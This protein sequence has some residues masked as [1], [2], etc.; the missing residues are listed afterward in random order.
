MMLRWLMTVLVCLFVSSSVPVSAQGGLEEALRGLPP[1]ERT[2]YREQL[3][4]LDRVASRLLK[5]VPDAPQVNF[6]LA[7]GENSVNAGATFGKVIVTEGMMRFVNSDDELAMILGHEFAH[8]TQGHVT[9]GAVNNTLLGIGS[10]I[11]G[12][13]M[14]GAGQAT[15]LVGQL[16]LNRFNQS[17]ERE[18]DQVGLRYVYAAG[19]SPEAAA[20][21]MQRMAE[22]V[23]QTAAAGFF[24]SHPSSIERFQALQQLA[25]QLDTGRGERYVNDNT[26]PQRS[27]SGRDEKVCQKA[28]PYFHQAQ[29]AG[30]LNEKVKLYR[31]GLRLCPQ[32]PRAHSELADVYIELGEE[33]KA[34]AE[35]REVLRYDAEY[36]EARSRLRGLEDNLSQLREW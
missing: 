1:G 14:P 23:P 21:V 6:I 9:R 32:S 10:A 16:F 30:N 28:R 31:S 12:V 18:A 29:D 15:N 17:Q 27:R 7:A 33:R 11:A 34:M 5:A 13:F 2:M 35:L 25:R 3:L 24:S 20:Q 8:L 4:R 26:Q 36:P 19:F 22:E